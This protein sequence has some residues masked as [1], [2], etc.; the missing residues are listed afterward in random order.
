MN[1][2]GQGQG[3]AGKWRGKYISKIKNVIK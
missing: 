2:R 1:W 3:G